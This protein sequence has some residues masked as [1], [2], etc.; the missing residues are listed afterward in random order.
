LLCVHKRERNKCKE[1]GGSS[2]CE[3]KRERN[4]CKDCSPDGHLRK[5]IKD[6]IATALGCGVDY[7]NILGCTV[8]DFREHLEAKLLLPCNV[9]MTWDNYGKGPGTWQIDH[10]VPIMYRE[11]GEVP[12]LEQVMKR[13]HWTNTQPLWTVDNKAKSNNLH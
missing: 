3:H 11:N 13:L 8:A 6:R 10:I 1:C 7:W 9:G 4:Q 2:I 5:I 12:Q